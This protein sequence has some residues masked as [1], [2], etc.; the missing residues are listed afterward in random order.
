MYQKGELRIHTRLYNGIEKL[1]KEVISNKAGAENWAN[2]LI[3]DE[4]YDMMY[5][6]EH[7]EEISIDAYNRLLPMICMKIVAADP[8]SNVL[9]GES[10]YYDHTGFQQYD[11]V[12]YENSCLTYQHWEGD[13]FEVL[14]PKCGAFV[15]NIFECGDKGIICDECG[16]SINFESAAANCNYIYKYENYCFSDSIFLK[17]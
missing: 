5:V 6:S 9:F 13:Q 11:T 10:R 15:C 1:I 16:A 8:E 7:G 2:N 3:L 12:R 17:Q 4:D 14:C